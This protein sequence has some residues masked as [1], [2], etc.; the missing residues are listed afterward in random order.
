MR[1]T[2]RDGFSAPLWLEDYLANMSI[3]T[4]AY[5]P[6]ATYQASAKTE[7]NLATMNAAVLGGFVVQNITDTAG[8]IYAITLNQFKAYESA[9]KGLMPASWDLSGIVPRK[10]TINTYD[11]AYTQLV[12]VFA[13][14][15]GT[16]P[17]TVTSIQ[18]G[19]IL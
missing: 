3:A 4:T 18:V 5:D 1:I 14:N 15:H 9:N 11:W 8:Y 17:S 16:Y 12:K 10:I 2:T 19:R 7:A 6:I 13:D